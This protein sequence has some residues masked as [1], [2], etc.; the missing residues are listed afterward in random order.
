MSKFKPSNIQALQHSNSKVM[1]NVLAVITLLIIIPT[2][3]S[4]ETIYPASQQQGTIALVHGTLHIGN[5]QLIDDGIIVFSNGKIVDV[6]KYAP[7][8]DVKIIDCT[9]KQIYPGLIA[10]VT[11]LGLNEIGAV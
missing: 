8:A 9:G 2:A 1:K 11:N 3:K 5:G 6:R 7:I 10:P 4:Q